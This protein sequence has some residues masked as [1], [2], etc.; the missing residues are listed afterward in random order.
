LITY[1]TPELVIWRKFFNYL[2]VELILAKFRL[3]ETCEPGEV[4]ERVGIPEIVKMLDTFQGL[5]YVFALINSIVKKFHLLKKAVSTQR[6]EF[7]T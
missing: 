3:A 6:F 5:N 2:L 4:F 7:L 1:A